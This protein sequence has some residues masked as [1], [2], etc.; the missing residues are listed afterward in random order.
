MSEIQAKR[1]RGQQQQKLDRYFVTPSLGDSPM[2]VAR[3]KAREA[4]G[5]MVASRSE[6]VRLA[7]SLSDEQRITDDETSLR[8]PRH[9]HPKRRSS[10]P[11]TEKELHDAVD[12]E[13]LTKRAKHDHDRGASSYASKTVSLI[14]SDSLT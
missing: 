7:V 13:R 10:S 3:N 5:Q 2:K 14:R 6:P 12:D 9:P 11:Y 8:S 1:T 4:S